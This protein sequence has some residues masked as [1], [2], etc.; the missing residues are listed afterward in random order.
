MRR[1][2]QFGISTILLLTLLTALLAARH[3]PREIKADITLVSVSTDEPEGV[4][5]ITNR[6][7]NAIFY[8]GY[9]LDQPFISVD[10]RSPGMSWKTIGIGFCGTGAALHKLPAGKSADFPIWWR[11]ETADQVRVKITCLDRNHYEANR[12]DI[13]SAPIHIVER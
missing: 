8:T 4:C 10:E 7:R 5:R 13:T 11:T 12:R 3:Q 2:F 9:A 1:H 6:G